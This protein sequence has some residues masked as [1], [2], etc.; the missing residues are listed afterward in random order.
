MARDP[1]GLDPY[2]YETPNGIRYEW[3]FAG[4]D[5]AWYV[6]YPTKDQNG[7]MVK[8]AKRWL[9]FMHDVVC[10]NTVRE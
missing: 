6:L 5:G 9:W 8:A 7:E 2:A 4:P 1:E 10:I 3:G